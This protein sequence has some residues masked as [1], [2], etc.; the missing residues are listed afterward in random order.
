[1]ANEASEAFWDIQTT[2]QK[3]IIELLK[4][5]GNAGNAQEALHY[6]QAACNAANAAA[7]S[8]N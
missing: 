7:C 6:T 8:R 2:A 4:R 5:A 3:V 1:M